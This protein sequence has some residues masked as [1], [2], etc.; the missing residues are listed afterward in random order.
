[1]Y[2]EGISVAGSVLDVA[3]DLGLVRKSGAWFYLGEERLGQGRENAKDFLKHNPDVLEDIRSRIKAASPELSGRLAFDGAEAAAV[4]AGSNG[5]G[6]GLPP[7]DEDGA[8]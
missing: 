2:N 4:A 7:A 6:D 3:T 1:M 8:P 5:R